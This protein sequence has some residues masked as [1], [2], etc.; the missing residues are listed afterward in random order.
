MRRGPFLQA[1]AGAATPVKALSVAEPASW[2]EMIVR[3]ASIA[4]T[5]HGS[6]FRR[7]SLGAFPVGTDGL[8]GQL[9]SGRDLRPQHA[10]GG[11]LDAE[12]IDGRDRA[13]IAATGRRVFLVCRGI[14]PAALTALGD[15]HDTLVG[16]CPVFVEPFAANPLPE[17]AKR[18][19]IGLAPTTRKLRLGKCRRS[20]QRKGQ[21]SQPC[22]APGADR[23][24]HRLAYFR[25]LNAV[26]A[27]TKLNAYDTAST[28][29]LSISRRSCSVR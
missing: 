11:L 12:M 13:R 9:V 24:A 17:Q 16:P 25:D 3:L 29:A 5:S 2:P 15:K 20:Q 26:L 8:K 1:A 4:S 28:I 6:R 21:A 14:N 18:S 10:T 27:C 7:C 22:P 19:V 23:V